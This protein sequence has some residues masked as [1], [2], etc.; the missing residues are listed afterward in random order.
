MF[1]AP[2]RRLFPL[3]VVLSVLVVAPGVTEAGRGGGGFRGSGF[4]GGGFGGSGFG[5]GGAG[6]FGG[7]GFQPGSRPGN[8]GEGVSFTGSG[9]RPA[10]GFRPGA[11][12]PGAP[13][14]FET[15]ARPTYGGYRPGTLPVLGGA[16]S[17][18]PMAGSHESILAN[19][20]DR[21][22][23]LRADMADRRGLQNF[24]QKDWQ[25][26]REDHPGEWQNW[27]DQSRANLQSWYNDRHF[28]YGDWYHGGWNGNGHSWW[29][30]MWEDH[31]AVVRQYVTLLG[32]E[33]NPSAAP[34]PVPS[35]T[36]PAPVERPDLS[37]EQLAGSW[38]AIGPNQ[39]TFELSLKADNG[40]TCKF[41]RGEKT[42][43]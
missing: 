21:V 5:G 25:H 27:R 12:L 2:T 30:H 3:A 1:P 23:N 6:R 4:G 28:H 22:A 29:D 36:S 33:P 34:A 9:L 32:G 35:A 14:R 18:R 20:T 26:W 37:A 11:A 15:G 42:Q 41:T 19:R 40:F 17:S 43:L 31:T 10:E 8:G 38:K 13:G 7:G 16:G 39:G 24:S